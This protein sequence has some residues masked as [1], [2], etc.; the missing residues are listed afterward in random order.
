[1]IRASVC[2][3]LVAALVYGLSASELGQTARSSGDPLSVVVC[4]SSKG[5]S[6]SLLCKVR[7]SLHFAFGA[8]LSETKI[9]MHLYISKIEMKKQLKLG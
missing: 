4:S 7:I 2:P 3:A 8:I 9:F 5:S 1:M 6:L